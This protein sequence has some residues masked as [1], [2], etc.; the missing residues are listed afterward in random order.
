VNSQLPPGPRMPAALQSLAT[1]YRPTAFLDRARARY[2]SRFT[3]RVLGQVP[4]VMLCDPEEIKALFLAAPNVVH[5]GEGARVLEPLVGRRSVILLDEDPHLEQRKLM[6]PAFHGE[7]MER[8]AGLMSELAQRE[9]RS[10]PRE[11]PI[12]LHPRLQGLTLE[13]ILRAVFGLRQG[14]RLD[15]LRRVLGAILAFAVKSSL[16]A[17]DAARRART[18]RSGGPPNSALSC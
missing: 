8:L 17:A 3:V 5:P 10:W 15:A 16:A 9:V 4:F 11:E 6:L 7:R 2:G 14:A 1:W 18:R 13:I 12:E